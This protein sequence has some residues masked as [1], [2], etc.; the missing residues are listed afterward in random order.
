MFYK[1]K[2]LFLYFTIYSF[3]GWSLE[4]FYRS[5]I[6]SHIVF[7]G[8]LG[9]PLCPIYGF[10]AILFI[11]FLDR[12]KDKWYLIFIFGCLIAGTS[13]YISSFILEK[14][15]H[16]IWWDYSGVLLNING[17][18]CVRAMIAFGLLAIF[19]IK[20]LHPALT[21]FVNKHIT[22][23]VLNIIDLICIIFIVGA[24]SVDVFKMVGLNEYTDCAE[25]TVSI[26]R[27]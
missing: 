22:D 19:L 10:V 13:E 17:R 3:I 26:Y 24:L 14:I 15:F 1:L 16:A 12:F 27:S 25:K 7:P 8:F 23:K 6:S 5:L 21:K 9:V 18:T 2:K 4:F 20:I 11:L